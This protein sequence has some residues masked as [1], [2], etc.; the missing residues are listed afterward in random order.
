MKQWKY[1][2]AM[3]LRIHLGS[4]GSAFRAQVYVGLK[5]SGVRA[6]SVAV[7]GTRYKVQGIRGSMSFAV[8]H[9]H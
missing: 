1:C 5:N 9:G 8:I 4:K 7:Q 2:A 3:G 6:K